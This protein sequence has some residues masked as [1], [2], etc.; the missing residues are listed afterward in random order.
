MTIMLYPNKI[1]P[2]GYRVQDKVY[3]INEYFP[4][5][6]FN[7]KSQL[8]ASQRQLELDEK[9]KI[10]KIRLSMDIN[11]IFKSTGEVIGLKRCIKKKAGKNVDVLFIQIGVNG[12]QKK[13]DIS[14]N[15]KTFKEAYYIA[16]EKILKLRG[17]ERDREL[18]LFFNKAAHRYNKFP[19]ETKLLILAN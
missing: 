17:I 10:R 2:L 14:M 18:T 4:F 16:Q 9:R 1:K 3:E 8:L 19:I 7:D 11:I 13:T 12:K 5:S 15:G 6:K